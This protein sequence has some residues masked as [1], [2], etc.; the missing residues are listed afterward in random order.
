MGNGFQGRRGKQESREEAAA[1]TW[2]GSAGGKGV[3]LLAYFEN[4]TN[5]IC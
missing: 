4:T 1:L 2:V 3:K 5:G